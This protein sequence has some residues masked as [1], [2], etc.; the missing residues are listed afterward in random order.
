MRRA[1]IIG[2][3]IGLVIPLGF[4][5]AFAIFGYIFSSETVVLWPSSIVLMGLE[6]QQNFA[7]IV[8][9]WAGA[10][11]VN[12]ALYALLALF[13]YLLYRGVKGRRNA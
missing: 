6:G 4:W 3:A 5:L 2:A 13:A 7:V 12:V 11:L 10:M 8:A 1:V 9:V